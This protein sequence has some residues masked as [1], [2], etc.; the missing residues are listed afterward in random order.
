M[1]R[2]CSL[3]QTL[4]WTKILKESEKLH[5][6]SE[7]ISAIIM[8]NEHSNIIHNPLILYSTLT[9][10]HSIL[11]NKKNTYYISS[12]TKWHSIYD[13]KWH[14]SV[15][16][17]ELHGVHSTLPT[18]YYTD[19]TNLSASSG[20]STSLSHTITNDLREHHLP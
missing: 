7:E 11:L 18:L 6:R 4:E 10:R 12:E 20:Q 8:H 5:C 16:N 2:Y 13:P 3:Q 17:M 9:T 15:Y 1:Q 14:S 19:F